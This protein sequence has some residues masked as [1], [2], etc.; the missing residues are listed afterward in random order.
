MSF[1]QKIDI[2]S[3]L[4][5][6]DSEDDEEFNT[7][8]AKNVSPRRPE[9]TYLFP[10][11]RAATPH[12]SMVMVRLCDTEKMISLLRENRWGGGGGGQKGGTSS[13]SVQSVLR[14]EP[15]LHRLSLGQT[16]SS[17]VT[18]TALDYQSSHHPNHFRDIAC[19][20]LENTYSSTRIVVS[21][22]SLLPSIAWCK[23][24]LCD[25]LGLVGLGSG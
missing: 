15:A 18:V 21:I 13:V 11:P 1:H 3:V 12:K 14:L 17:S 7:P 25:G 24:W 4:F 6:E 22:S 23:L 20:S 9:R 10:P 19:T 5:L 8:G 16:P 2:L